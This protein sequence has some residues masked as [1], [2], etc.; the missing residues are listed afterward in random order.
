MGEEDLEATA[1]VIALDVV[2]VAGKPVYAV[3]TETCTAGTDALTVDLLDIVGS[4]IGGRHIVLHTESAVVAADFLKPFHT[5]T[6]YTTTVGGDDEVAGTAHNLEV[7]AGAP[8]LADDALR[9]ALAEEKCGIG[10]GRVIIVGIDEPGEHILAVDCLDPVRLD[11]A[12]TH[13]IEGLVVE[14]G[15][16]FA[17]SLVVVEVVRVE[18]GGI[19]HRNLR[20]DDGVAIKL[21]TID[22]VLACGNLTDF[23]AVGSTLIAFR[24]NFA[25]E[26]K[27]LQ[28]ALVH[29]DGQEL[30]VVVG[31][32]YSAD[33][34]VKLGCEVGLFAGGEV[35]NHQTLLVSLVAVALHT[36]PSNVFAII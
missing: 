9:T 25:V 32:G 5:E 11:F 15:N 34:V 23:N 27:D 16:L 13:L 1:F 14:C 24:V 22:I 17:L 29:N 12:H 19:L 28:C 10:L 33:T 20:G 18:S 3:A 8:E 36:L 31:P 21:E 7:P 30:L 26:G 35:H 4:P 6:G 2:V